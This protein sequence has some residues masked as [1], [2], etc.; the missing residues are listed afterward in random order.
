MTDDL[1]TWGS[2]IDG[3]GGTVAAADGLSQLKSVVSGWR[4]RGIPSAH[5]SA[6]VRLAAER[7]NE[8]ITLEVLADLAA[9]RR[10]L[11]TA[12]VRA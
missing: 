11:L 4:E 1:S 12:E 9:R 2:I 8:E 3:L 10:A 7:G 6:V 5:W